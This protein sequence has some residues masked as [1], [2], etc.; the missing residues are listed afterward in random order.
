MK[1]SDLLPSVLLI[2]I[3]GNTLSTFKFLDTV[4]T[5]PALS[6]ATTLTT[7]SPEISGS[8]G[9]VV[10]GVSPFNNEFLAPSS[11]FTVTV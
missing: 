10:I 2:V 9:I 3:V 11:P 4:V 7:I 1:V 6:I 5:F 8:T